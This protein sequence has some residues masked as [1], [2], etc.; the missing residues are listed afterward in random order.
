ML[1]FHVGV[2]ATSVTSRTARPSRTPS[3]LS[4]V[5]IRFFRVEERHVEERHRDKHLSSYTEPLPSSLHMLCLLWHRHVVIIVWQ[6]Q[7]HKHIIL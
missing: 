3:S 6:I 5:M 1:C 4:R 7:N 2:L